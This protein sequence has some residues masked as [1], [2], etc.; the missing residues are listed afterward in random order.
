MMLRYP[1]VMVCLSVHLS[2]RAGV[3][4]MKCLDGFGILHRSSP[5]LPDTDWGSDEKFS[6]VPWYGAEHIFARATA[7]TVAYIYE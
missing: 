5:L 6:S 3:V 1:G 4:Y 7:I 2:W